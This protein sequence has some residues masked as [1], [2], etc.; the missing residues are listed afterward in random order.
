MTKPLRL[1]AIFGGT[2]LI[3]L[4]AGYVCNL[5][6]EENPVYR[7]AY[8]SGAQVVWDEDCSQYDPKPVKSGFPL[9]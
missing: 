9:I 2:F 6:R 3:A 1:L 7:S 5:P 4:L 8:C